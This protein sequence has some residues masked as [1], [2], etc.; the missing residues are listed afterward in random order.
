MKLMWMMIFFV[1][2]FVGLGYALWHISYG[3]FSK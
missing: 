2:P 1:L 3:V